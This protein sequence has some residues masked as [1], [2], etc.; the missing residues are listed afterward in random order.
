MYKAIGMNAVGI[1]L[2]IEETLS[3]AVTYDFEGVYLDIMQVMQF[4]ENRIIDMLE[5]LDLK[6]AGFG[7]P[8]NFRGNEGEYKKDMEKFEQMAK[9][10]SMIG[11]ERCSTYILPFSDELDFDQNFDLHSKRLREI[12]KILI[13]YNINIGLE[14]VGPKTLRDGHKYEFIHDM[15]GMLE[16]C[17]AIGTDNTGLLMDSYH[18]YT[19]HH[20]IEDIKDLGGGEMIID[21]HV[22]DAPRGVLIDEQLDNVRC[23]PAETGVIDLKG[24]LKAIKDLGYDG[25]VMVEPFST[26]L[27]NMD[28]HSILRE[29]RDSLDRIWV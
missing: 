26:R 9:A 25:P 10:A 11:M 8:V 12:A 21:V 23:I 5:Q 18:W 13:D 7:L 16:L 24:F 28:V 2:P 17:H 29:V 6:A 15:K 3:L 27:K 4:G 22:N 20:T 19:A 14:F 1:N